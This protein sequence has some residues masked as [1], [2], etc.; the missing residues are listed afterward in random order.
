MLNFKASLGTDEQ[1]F[2]TFIKWNPISCMLYCYLLHICSPK[3]RRWSLWIIRNFNLSY[4]KTVNPFRLSTSGRHGVRHASKNSPISKNSINWRTLM[5]YWLAWI[6]P[7][8]KKK[9]W[10]PLSRNINSNRKSCTSM[11][12]MK[13]IGSMKSALRGVAL[14]PQVWS[15]PKTDDGFMSSPSQRMNCSM[16]SSLT[17]K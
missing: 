13:I 7:N 1:N 10:Y 11:M 8:T 14:C 5:C 3:P 2:I 4:I 6:F 17:F 15:T 16:R 9:D 12:R